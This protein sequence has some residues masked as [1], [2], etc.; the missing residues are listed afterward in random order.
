MVTCLADIFKPL[1]DMTQRDSAR[2]K[3]FREDD[4][5]DSSYTNDSQCDGPGPKIVIHRCDIYGSKL[6]PSVGENT[7]FQMS[8]DILRAYVARYRRALGRN[9]RILTRNHARASLGHD[10][11]SVYGR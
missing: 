5:D 10:S 4:S 11:P 7:T 8:T 2:V 9:R 3:A 1:E 6:P